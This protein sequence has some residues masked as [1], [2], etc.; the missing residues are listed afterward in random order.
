MKT[1]R[2]LKEHV[3][4]Y[5]ASLI[6]EGKLSA[7]DRVSEQSVCDAIG[8]SHTPVREALIQLSSDGYLDNEPRRGFKVK[9][10]DEDSAREI[11]ETIG[12][13]D[14][15]AARLARPRMGAEDI[16]ELCFLVDSMGLAI[17]QGLLNNYDKLQRDFHEYYAVRC[18]NE[19]LH[20]LLHQLNRHFIRH[21]YA[22][23]SREEARRLVGKANDEHRRIVEL[24]ERGA[25]NEL[26]DYIRDVHWDVRNAKFTTW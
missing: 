12:P 5:I 26:S 15:Q 25:L 8:V 2:S 7:G 4:D 11:F 24:F 1:Y 3:Y 13:L 17:E 20:Q 18:G 10:F 9:G 21:D 22:Q 19:R 14:G 16:R 23:V 6:N